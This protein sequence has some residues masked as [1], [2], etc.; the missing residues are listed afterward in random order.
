M[1]VKIKAKNKSLAV[2]DWTE[3][4]PFVNNERAVLIHRPR[5]VAEH[6]ISKRWAPHL[7]ITTWCGNTFTGRR[8][9]TFLDAPP[10]GRLL[11]QRC[12]VAAF[13]AGEPT[14]ESITG[15]HVHLGQVIA[16]QTCCVNKKGVK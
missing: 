13:A 6:Q 4:Q 12:E 5:H 2:K 15:G 7:A 11:C 9:F 16:V 3:V 10:N 8:Q 1:I 14:A